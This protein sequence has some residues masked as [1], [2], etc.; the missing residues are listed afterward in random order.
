MKNT[1]KSSQ[2]KKVKKNF[3]FGRIGLEFFAY[4]DQLVD[5]TVSRVAPVERK[6]IFAY[7]SRYQEKLFLMEP[8]EILSERPKVYIFVHFG[9][10]GLKSRLPILIFEKSQ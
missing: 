6:S 5:C 10:N 7:L 4:H 2:H 1:L 9:T 3:F 8:F